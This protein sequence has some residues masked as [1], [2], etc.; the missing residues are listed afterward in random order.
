[1][2]RRNAEGQEMIG[3]ISERKNTK[4]PV[5]GLSHI[6]L[7]VKDMQRTVD[8]YQGILGFPLIKTTELPGGAGQHFFFDMG[9]GHGSLAF[10]FFP[11]AKEHAPGVTVTRRNIGGFDEDG[12]PDIC[13]TDIGSMNHISFNVEPDRILECKAKL[14]AVGIPVSEVLE[15]YDFDAEGNPIK[16]SLFLSSIYFKDPDGIQLEFG[17]WHRPFNENDT[18]HVPARADE[19]EVWIEGMQQRELS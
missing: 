18:A 11:T 3:Q 16:E 17:A 7:V 14:E 19:A 9:D 6:A 4:F 5:K 2:T 12:L 15:H 13:V 1:M 8:F 10:F